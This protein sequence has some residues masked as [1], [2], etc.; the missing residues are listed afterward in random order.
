MNTKL[1]LT[2]V[3]ALEL[4]V[5]TYN[6]L[7]AE[8]I[9]TIGDLVRR[10][11][12]ELLRMPNFGR[13]SLTEVKEIL[14]GRNLKLGMQLD[15]WPP[16]VL[17]KAILEIEHKDTDADIKTIR[18]LLNLVIQKSAEKSYMACMDDQPDQ[19]ALYLRL[20][21]NA[22]VLLNEGNPK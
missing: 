16:S 19:A 11:E 18:T 12:L 9:F 8:N 22:Q 15:N 17:T 7:K 21:A 2:P 6:C 13:K 10:T 20:I 1:L 5:R 4:T 14:W 3:D